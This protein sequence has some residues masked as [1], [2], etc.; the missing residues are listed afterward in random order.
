MLTMLNGGEEFGELTITPVQPLCKSENSQ[1][2]NLI[3]KQIIS[4]FYRKLQYALWPYSAW[5]ENHNSSQQ[6][7]TE[8]LLCAGLSAMGKV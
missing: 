8:G 6:L 2:N 5:P 1:S 3:W 7:Y 4:L